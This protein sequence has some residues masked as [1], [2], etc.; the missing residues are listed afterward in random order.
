MRTTQGQWEGPAG[1]GDMQGL[2]ALPGEGGKLP[3][4]GG[5][6]L[7]RGRRILSGGD[8]GR[9]TPGRGNSLH[10]GPEAGSIWPVHG[11]APSLEQLEDGYVFKG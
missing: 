3:R 8:G 6:E 9:G 11:R 4:R 5:M 2:S 7:R 10:S 1:A